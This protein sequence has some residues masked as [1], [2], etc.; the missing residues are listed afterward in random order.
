MGVHAHTIGSFGYPETRRRSSSID[1]T[2]RKFP[3]GAYGLCISGIPDGDSL[4]G[5]AAEDW[6]A[7]EVTVEVG[8]LDAD[9]EQ[10]D[11]D[12]ALLRLRTGGWIKLRREPGRALYVVPTPLTTDELV[13]PFLAPAA[14]LFAHWHGRE[15]LHGGALAVGGTAWGVIGDRFGG[16]SS[17]L[18]AL[19][20]AGT[21]V[22]CDD[23]LILDGRMTYPGPRT[24][25]LREDAAAALAVGEQIGVAGARER[26]RVRLG[27]L[28]RPL[29]IGGWVFTEWADTLELNRLPASE[30]L[31]RL[32]R[33]R[34]IRVPPRDPAAFLQLSALP[35]WELRRPR[36]WS[37]LPETLEL[38]LG[39]LGAEA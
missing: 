6:P 3:L 28:D 7:L 36:S 19:A 34:S 37:S 1:T 27:S 26:W 8:E 14:A 25:D 10:L 12:R 21:D 18:A 15:G 29:W 13:H 4:L 22:V 39:V 2:Q 24:I 16:K 11:H 20:V 17:L 35:A 9:Q 30:A 32:F 23:V 38:L 5:R 31:T 33:N